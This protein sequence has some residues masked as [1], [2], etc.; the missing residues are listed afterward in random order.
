MTNLYER[1][2]STSPLVEQ[3]IKKLV[4]WSEKYFA[5]N[6][7]KWLPNNKHAKILDLACGFGRYTKILSD[8]GY[9]NVKGVDL[10]PEQVNY[11]TEIMGLN[12]VEQADVSNWLKDKKDSFDCI[13]ALDILEHL[14]NDDLVKMGQSIYSSLKVNGNVIIQVPNAVSPINHIIYGDLT[15]VRA[16][17]VG[18]LRQFLLNVGFHH[19]QFQSALPPIHGVKSFVRRILWLLTL[20]PAIKA[21]IA[22]VHGIDNNQGIYTPNIIAIAYKR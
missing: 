5:C 8:M 10:S 7:K 11:A 20:L 3:D 1:Y 9:D 15:H 14:V 12:N 22:I 19:I 18:S 21:Y 16:F 17:T 6:Y 4:T 2:T 13:L